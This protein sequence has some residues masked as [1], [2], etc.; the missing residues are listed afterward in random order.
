[1]SIAVVSYSLTGNNGT[2]AAAVAKTL[3]AEHIIILEEKPR[4]MGAII[5]DMIFN[6]TPRVQSLPSALEQYERILFIAPVW[7]GKVASPLRA[8]LKHLKAHP[9]SY[10]FASISGGALNMNPKLADDLEKR[11]GAK[12]M[13]FV[14]LHIADLL[15]SELKPTMKDTSSYR[16]SDAEISKLAGVIVAS[17]KNTM[18]L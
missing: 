10:A 9:Q 2:L 5:L 16:L 6:R 13:A 12:P 1:M 17:V 14:D 11:A 8:F 15:P 4:K 3:S 18:G 7:M